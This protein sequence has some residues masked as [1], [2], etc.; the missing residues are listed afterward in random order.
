ME[1]QLRDGHLELLVE[2]QVYIFI[3]VYLSESIGCAGDGRNQLY[4]GFP[5]LKWESNFT[6]V[7]LCDEVKRNEKE[8]AVYLMRMNFND[9]GFG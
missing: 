2:M 1:L 9:Y 7:S 3:H 5:L 8:N 4:F 6:S